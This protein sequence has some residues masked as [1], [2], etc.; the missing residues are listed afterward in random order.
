MAEDKFEWVIEKNKNGLQFTI[1][2]AGQT[3][4]WEIHQYLEEG[5]SLKFSKV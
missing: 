5:R 3:G 1:V 4:S 2:E